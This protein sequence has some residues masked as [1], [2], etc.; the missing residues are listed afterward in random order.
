VTAIDPLTGDLLKDPRKGFLPPN[1]QDGIG[2]GFV[3]YSI[4][5]RKDVVTGTVIDAQARIIF[6]NNEP[7]D[8]PAI[9]NTI[10]ADKP[11][12]SVLELPTSTETTSFN[13]K[14]LG[15][16]INN[17]SALAS[18]TVYVSDNGG[19]YTPWLTDT[20]LTE[21]TFVGQPGHTYSF[22]SIARDNA[23][24][25]QTKPTSAQAT[26][27]VNS[28]A[29]VLS[30]N[31]SLT[32]DEASQFVITNSL[33]QI[34]D[35]DSSSSN[36][37]YRIE[38][39]PI[40]G[41]LLLNGFDLYV[42]DLFTQ[43]D[44]DQGLLS[45]QHNGSET[46]ADHFTFTVVDEAGNALPEAIF[47]INVNSVND[48][49]IANANKSVVVDEDAQPTP[50]G[51]TAP[52]DAEGDSLI[53]TVAAI[54]DA[55]KGSISIS[56][57]SALSINQTLSV[58]ELEQLT[59]VPNSNANGLAGIFSYIVSD[60]KGG[61]ATQSIALDITPVNDAPIANADKTLIL[62]EDAAPLAL[63]ITAPIDAENDPLTI[64]VTAL[65]NAAAGQI[66]LGNGTAVSLNQ[67]LSISELQQLVF[68]SAT[69]ANGAAGAFRYTVNDSNGGTA[70]Q[71]VAL[72]ITPVNDAPVVNADKTLTLFEDAA[73]TSL[74]I[75]APTDVDGD[76]LTITVSALVD[77]SKG[78]IHLANG[79]SVSLN[80]TLSLTEIQQ[81]IF[82]PVANVN[83]AAGSF[84]YTV[85]DGNGGTA[86]QAVTLDI[87]PVNDAPVAFADTA[88][89]N[90]NTPLILS[91]ATLLAN[92]TDIEGDILR[93]SGVSNAIN[94]TVALNASGNAVFTPTPGFSGIG[95]FNYTITD[96]SSTGTAT[97]TITVIDPSIILQGTTKNDTLTGK[98][99]NDQLYGN[100]GNDTLIGNAGDDLLDGGTGNDTLIGGLGN[101]IH[102]VNTL[103]DLIT[104]NS[105]EGIDTVQSSISWTLENN[106]ENLTL[107]GTTAIN[108]TGNTLDNTLT[109]N[110]GNNILDGG[111]GNDTLIGK[112][113]NDTYIVDSTSD[114]ITELVGE[115]T[116]TVKSSITWVLGDNLENLTLTDS[117]SINGTGN[118]LNNTLTG[119]AGNNILD[120]GAGND[121]L[122]GGAGDDT[123]VVDSTSDRIT[124]LA[125]GGTDT[126]QSSV[127]WTLG[128]NL[129]NLV[130]TGSTAINGTGNTLDNTLTGNAGNNI[131]D[132]GAGNDTLTGGAGD[133]TYVVDSISDLITEL[134][135]EGTD[136]V[137][138][139]VN[140]TLG[141]NLENLT[142]TG[143]TALSG[144]GNALDNI[145]IA[146]S[147]GNIFDGGDGN[148]TLTGGIG[149]D[150]LIGGA[151]NDQ[152]VGETGRDNLTGGLGNDILSLGSDKSIDTVFYRKGD[153][154]DTIK[155]FVKGAGGDLLSFNG[156]THIDVVKSGQNTEFRISDGIAGN[157]GFGTQELLMTLEGTTGFNALNI[158]NNLALTN[159][160]QF[161]F[162]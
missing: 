107:T 146:N 42:S 81:L 117:S 8:T 148:D 126:V 95:S 122:T 36:L 27:K 65:P 17:G 73:S 22:Y 83:G 139:S 31:Q 84:R 57:G 51:I 87:T 18:Y 38:H 70:T 88:T 92:D 7:I 132:G 111:A 82:A 158:S 115:G 77:P 78:V 152:L 10:D 99:G 69:N 20:T 131:L 100:A 156:I 35:A 16:D 21:S 149:N 40:N 155:Q 43:A 96:G 45:Y 32:L 125:G 50:L 129:E 113:G 138:S 19:T 4:R 112:A 72:D 120:G 116:D 159:T 24:N 142:L 26:I 53:I 29:P 60:G 153:G 9:F 91:P 101:D 104:E 62:L 52:I 130:L 14:W 49:P 39:L 76:A 136:T 25:V 54:P 110:T 33:L 134:A 13:V 61:H 3:N 80:Q 137:K 109:G 161:W 90:A 59:F 58:T 144:T 68:A 46:N 114:L 12:S 74:G 119:N 48:S 30:L 106:L 6:D 75:T 66:R 150:T 93:L 71:T 56:G 37:Y 147:A 124:E 44:V 160:T 108:G 79:T 89:T 127:T 143:T 157:Q 63:G 41:Q 55:G 140:W 105:D 123:Y 94:G 103:S 128:T 34:T 23:G 121:T 15:E 98:S 135:G 151:G 11:V 154:V 86:T 47:N 141:N 118:A 28:Q 67:T 162:N 64:T 2:E 97:V 145:M 133:D 1:T 5:S 102:V 85:N